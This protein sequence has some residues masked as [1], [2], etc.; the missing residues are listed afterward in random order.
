[1]VWLKRILS[2]TLCVAVLFSVVYM[3]SGSSGSFTASA[4]TSAEIQ[5]QLDALKQESN[6]IQA[7]I[8]SLEATNAPNEKQRAAIKRQITA[9]MKEIDLHEQQITACEDEI[10]KL[11]KE[12]DEIDKKCKAQAEEFK[13]RLVAIYTG[14]N[15][16]LTD[17][18]FLMSSDSMSD[19]LAK[20]ELLETMTRRDNKIIEQ[21][22]KD[23]A[24]IEKKKTEADQK[25]AELDKTKKEMDAKKLELNKQYDKVNAIV[26]SYEEA[27]AQAEREAAEQKQREKDLKKALE[28]AK[29]LENGAN[30]TGTFAWPLPG[31]YKV[32]S[33][34]G[35]RY[36]PVSGQYKLHSGTDIAGA[37]C[38]GNKIVAADSGTVILSKYYGG[39]GNCVM[40]DHGNGYV[41]LYAHMKAL[42]PLK[43][44]DA[45]YKG[46]TVVGYVGSSG[47]STA[48][49]LHFEI[50]KN[51][52]YTDPMKYF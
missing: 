3:G 10:S 24:E 49:H 21:H 46:Q 47:T 33:P 22:K 12:I 23:V 40:I 17:L 32:T 26:L 39:Y 45:V 30:G 27:I 5:A 36:H 52:S 13:K 20:A 38:Y 16:F 42:S 41:T 1:M 31:F 6:R 28:E 48:P 19:Y 11:N 15:S 9:I 37:G 7:E 8:S 29:L 4:L 35:Y 25:K 14:K 2:T 18:S 44:G 43:V 50:I 51:G 34:Y